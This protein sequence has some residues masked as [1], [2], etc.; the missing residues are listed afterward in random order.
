MLGCRRSSLLS[1]GVLSLAWL[2]VPFAGPGLEAHLAQQDAHG[3]QQVAQA[4]QEDFERLADAAGLRAGGSFPFDYQFLAFRGPTDDSVSVWAAT[5]VHAGRMRGVFEGGWKYEISMKFEVFDGE[6]M[7]AVGTSRIEHTLSANI[8][9]ETSDGFPLQA[10]V[11]LAPGE[12]AYRVTVTDENWPDDRSVNV[13]KGEL[14]VP[15]MRDTRPLVSS[16][17]VAADSAGLW[18]PATR[19]ALK[20]NAARIVSKTARPFVY[21]EVYGLT[22]GSDYRGEVRLQSTWDSY[23]KDERFTGS[24]QPFELQYRGTAPDDPTQPVRSM[25]RLDMKN[26]EPGPYDIRVKVTDMATGRSSEVR[27][28]S[29]KVQDDE[30]KYFVVP[31]TEVKAARVDDGGSGRR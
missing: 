30:H 22:P 23:G 17:A 8:P 26:T 19:V 9:E 12:Y 14:H 24:Y 4:R 16:I 31:V 28:V 3:R 25:F 10:E 21:Y 5:S 29:L 1:C 20:L 11:W 15:S 27:Q 7:V 18:R 2:T 13:K 6:E